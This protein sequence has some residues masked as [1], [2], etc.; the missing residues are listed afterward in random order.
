MHTALP[1]NLLIL[2]SYKILH[3]IKFFANKNQRHRLIYVLRERNC[4]IINPILSNKCISNFLV[5][6]SILIDE[7]Y[8]KLE[9]C[10]PI[11][12]RKLGT[13]ECYS[14]N[15]HE[16]RKNVSLFR[17]TTSLNRVVYLCFQTVFVATAN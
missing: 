7:K 2:N 14:S 11:K 13:T 4:Q 5:L 10:R 6:N 16:C 15:Q 17:I 8:N 1:N 3:L 12:G 9:R